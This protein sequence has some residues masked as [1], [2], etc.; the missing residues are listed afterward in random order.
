MYKLNK[1]SV[2]SLYTFKC[3]NMYVYID[4]V[5]TLVYNNNI[6]RGHNMPKSKHRK[7]TPKRK[8]KPNKQLV[9]LI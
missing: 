9:H 2:K 6:E 4:F 3:T 8:P 1:D 5:H 7:K